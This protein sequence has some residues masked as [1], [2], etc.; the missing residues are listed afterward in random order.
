MQKVLAWLSVILVVVVGGKYAIDYMSHTAHENAA[1]S[2]VQAFL[3]GMTAGGD[4][5]DAF[6]MWHSGSP[7]G[8]GN[9]TQD[10]YN[11]YAAELKAWMARRDLGERIGD[12]EIHGAT[13]AQGPEG[14]EPSVVDVSCTVDGKPLVI[15][16]A[17]GERLEWAD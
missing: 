6:N 14:V 11:M 15:R 10:Q 1:T 3:D 7:G 12:Y 8:I 16:A 9:M 17:D 5:Q 4:F 13:M 2:R